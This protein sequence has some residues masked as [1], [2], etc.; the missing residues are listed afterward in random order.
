LNTHPLSGIYAAAVTPI[1][2]NFTPDLDGLLKLL[3]FLA[4]RGCH[5]ALL[6]GTTGEGPSFA[7]EERV[8]IWKQAVEV[9]Q[10]FPDFRLLAGT[11]TPSLVETVY[12]TKSAMDLGYDGVVVLPPYYFRNAKD[13]GLFDWFCELMDRAVPKD[14]SL[15][16]YHIPQVSGVSLSIN[17]LDRLKNTFPDRFCG[18]KDS[19]GIYDHTKEL[20]QRFEGSLLVFVGNDRLM[21]MNLQLGGAGCITALANVLSPHLRQMWEKHLQSEDLLEEQKLLDAVRGIT[22]NYPPPAPL[23]KTL[24]ARRH[25][26]PLW[27]VCPP[28][29][30]LTTEVEIMILEGM[31]AIRYP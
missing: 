2:T 13:E 10:S 5:G 3:H 1:N 28:L 31:D 7:P 16:G 22:D 9:R 23:I 24:L 15:F 20:I 27:K 4:N 19:S 18:L 14:G 21:K 30:S 11:G 25:G 17:L 8:A 6:L 12:L 26:F 29:Q